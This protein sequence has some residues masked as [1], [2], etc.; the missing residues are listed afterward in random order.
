MPGVTVRLWGPH[1]R[2]FEAVTNDLGYFTVKGRLRGTYTMRAVLPP[3]LH[4]PA[5][6]AAPAEQEVEIHPDECAGAEIVVSSLGTIEGRVVDPDGMGVV[7]MEVALM[8]A[9]KPHDL[10]QIATVDTDE[11]GRYVFEN[12]PAGVYSVAA[13]YEGPGA[14]RLPYP[15]TYYPDGGQLTDAAR[16]TLEPAGS[17]KLEEIRLP[18]AIRK[19]SVAGIVRWPDGR[20]AEGVAVV[21]GIDEWEHVWADTDANGRYE[22]TG[23]EGL[24]YELVAD[25]EWS[26]AAAHSEP[27]EL[28]LGGEDLEIDLVLDH[29]T[30]IKTPGEWHRQGSKPLVP[31][32]ERPY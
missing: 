18:P 17:V 1:G 28:V 32:E 7:A 29:P 3:G 16:L 11:K 4:S 20:P 10:Y 31:L 26:D 30:G 23:Y 13:N 14:D 19:V 15:P 8:P 24:R 9:D 2:R 22:V 21:L 5:A 25:G 27:R 12:V 6:P